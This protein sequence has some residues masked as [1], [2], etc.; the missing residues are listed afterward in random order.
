MSRERRAGTSALCWYT[1]LIVSV[2][3]RLKNLF[4]SAD[5]S[6]V[7]VRQRFEL[8]GKAGQGSMSKSFRARDRKRGCIVCLKILDKEQTARFEARFPGLKR[9]T[10]EIIC[11]AMHHP[12]IVATLEHGLTTSG[13]RYMVMEWVEGKGLNY[14]IEG[15]DVWLNGK[16]SSLL[17][18][19]ADG[20]AY[21]HQQGY[22][23]RD[24]CPRNIM[25]TRAG[26]AKIIDFGL[27]IPNRPEF[28]QAGNRTGTTHY[29][30]PEIIK[31][32]PTDHRVDLFALGVTAYETFTGRLPWE[33][34]DS[35]QILLNA[36]NSPGKDPRHYRAD[37][38]PALAAFLLKA[39]EREPAARFQTAT[40][41]R[42]ALLSLPRKDY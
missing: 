35:V 21:I 37:L 13:E 38:D 33:K 29:L 26:D 34:T 39:I 16:R 6:P 11:A 42:E 36:M 5:A 8:L 10:E 20:I 14:L 30:A 24:I 17:A 7:D 28:C 9:P 23:H 27:A 4:S 32:K 15:N 41:F 40:E 18:Q 12:N 3:S 19:A 2:F 22:L 25:V 31:R 1:D